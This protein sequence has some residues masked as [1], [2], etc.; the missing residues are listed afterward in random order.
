MKTL[1]NVSNHPSYKWS[2]EQKEGWEKII[3]IPFPDVNPYED[4]INH[5]V[6]DLVLEYTKKTK[7]LDTFYL[8]L[9]GEYSVVYSV[10]KTLIK[11]KIDTI[12]CIPTSQRIV[13]EVVDENGEVKKVSNFKFVKWRHINLND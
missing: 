9:A 3:D 7:E 6:R 13:E 1:I 2:K 12:L 8:H 5:I 11:Y 4:D 10:I